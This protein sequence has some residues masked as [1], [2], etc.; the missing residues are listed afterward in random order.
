MVGRF[1]LF[2]VV[3][4]AEPVLDVTGADV[5]SGAPSVRQE[6]EDE[7]VGCEGLAGGEDEEGSSSTSTR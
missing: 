4:H 2:D 3:V 5:S 7:V 1:C 6:A